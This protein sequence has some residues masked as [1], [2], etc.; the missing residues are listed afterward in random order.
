MEALKKTHNSKLTQQIAL[1]L[2]HKG[3]LESKGETILFNIVKTEMVDML[4]SGV[5][6]PIVFSYVLTVV[7]MLKVTDNYDIVLNY[8]K[9]DK[10]LSIIY[11]NETERKPILAQLISYC[12]KGSMK[13]HDNS[14][15]TGILEDTITK[16]GYL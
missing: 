15:L 2:Q 8:K 14:K 16:I 4:L 5:V 7:Q 10:V 6:V 3:E 1:Y 13:L 9:I 12:I 11:L